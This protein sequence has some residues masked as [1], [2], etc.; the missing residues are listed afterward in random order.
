MQSFH[1]INHTALSLSFHSFSKVNQKMHVYSDAVNYHSCTSIISVRLDNSTSDSPS[2]SKRLQ[3]VPEILSSVGCGFTENVAIWQAKQLLK[4][5]R[6]RQQRRINRPMARIHTWAMIFSYR[7]MWLWRTEYGGIMMN[8]PSSTEPRMTLLRSSGL[9][10]SD[11]REITILKFLSSEFH[12]ES[13]DQPAQIDGAL[14]VLD[15][16]SFWCRWTQ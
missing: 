3:T 7:P 5:C 11:N 1:L 6:L 12:D 2:L 9:W 16:D 8:S 10:L 14:W 15:D 4:D 13:Q